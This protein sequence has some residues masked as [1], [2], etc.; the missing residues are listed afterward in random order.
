MLRVS[1]VSL[2]GV[3]F[4][5]S[6]LR[7][8]SIPSVTLPKTTCRPSNQEVTTVQM[9]N[10]DPFVFGPA[11]AMDNVPGPVCFNLKFSSANFSP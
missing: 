9:K 3:P 2:G 1:V 5:A 7:T 8:T 11:L 4:K 10:C 6:I